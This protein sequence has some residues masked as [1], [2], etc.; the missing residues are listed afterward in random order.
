MTPLVYLRL[1]FWIKIPQ[2]QREE[3]GSLS[4]SEHQKLQRLWTQGGGAYG[5][6]WDLV[7]ANN[8]SVTKVRQFL[9]SKFSYTKFTFATQKFKWIKAFARFKKEVWFMDLAYVDKLAKNNNGVK[10]LLF[11]QNLFDGTVDARGMKTKDSKERLCAFLTIITKNKLSQ[12]N[13]SWQGNKL[14]WRV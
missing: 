4:K 9:H 2:L 1:L 14:C 11:R 13:L 6:V 10:Y 8:P 7:K 5:S 12:C 3:A